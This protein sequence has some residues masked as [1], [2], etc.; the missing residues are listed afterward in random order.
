MDATLKYY[1]ELRENAPIVYKGLTFHPLLMRHFALYQNARAAVELMQA[2]LP[3]RYA[4][5]PWIVCLMMMDADAEAEKGLKTGYFMSFLLIL[6]AALQTDAEHDPRALQIAQDPSG[7]FAA[8][9]VQQQGGAPVLLDAAALGDVRQI[10]AAQNDYSIPDENWNADLV[11]AQQYLREH[12]NGAGLSGSLDEAVYAVA[13]ATGHRAAEIWDW[14]IRE[15]LGMQSAV[16]RRLRF[17]IFTEAEF[18]GRI[19][20]RHGN[21]CPSWLNERKSVLPTGFMDLRE[22]E[23]GARGMLDTPSN[24]DT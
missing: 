16:D 6:D 20:F 3:V 1:D 15:Y 9:V 4:I 2:S 7:N 17:Q 13:A 8:L 11:R 18:S 5:K 21:P 12:R 23:A 24:T 10:I 19:K 22:L 14:P